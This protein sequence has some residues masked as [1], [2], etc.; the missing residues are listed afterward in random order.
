MDCSTSAL[1]CR[2]SVLRARLSRS[3]RHAAHISTTIWPVKP[4]NI[5]GVFAWMST[6]PVWVSNVTVSVAFFAICPA[7]LGEIEEV[8]IFRL[9]LFEN[10]LSL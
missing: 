7:F 3:A 10:T 9:S 4:G 6:Y 1:W 2:W 5:Y 8:A